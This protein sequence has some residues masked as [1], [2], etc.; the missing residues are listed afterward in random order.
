MSRDDSPPTYTLSIHHA[1][2][3]R[4]AAMHLPDRARRCEESSP[5]RLCLSTHSMEHVAVSAQAVTY[6]NLT[7]GHR[8]PSLLHSLP[9][10]LLAACHECSS[11]CDPSYSCSASRSGN[12]KLYLHKASTVASSYSSRHPLTDVSVAFVASV[13]RLLRRNRRSLYER[14][15]Q[16]TQQ[17]NASQ[18]QELT[19]APL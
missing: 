4:H 13:R 16:R 14:A 1:M 8:I 2:P 7:P 18:P 9:A 5:W 12:R 3:C 19:T 17:R 10:V 15:S 6:C 11:Q